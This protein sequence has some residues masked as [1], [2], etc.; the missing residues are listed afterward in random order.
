V[1]EL[2]LQTPIVPVGPAV[3]SEFEQQAG[4]AVPTH[5]LVLGQ[6]R[7]L[8]LHEMPQDVPLQVA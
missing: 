1:H 7:K 8:L 2:L 5:K 4:A 6:L 3:Q